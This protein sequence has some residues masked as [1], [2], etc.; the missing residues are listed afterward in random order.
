MT[1]SKPPIWFWIV[2]VLALLWNLLGVMAFVGQMAMTPDM[3]AQ[4]PEA[5]RIAIETR[6]VWATVAFGIAV[7]GGAVGS[8][9]LLLRSR[10]AKLL[11]IASLLGVIV[12]MA[13]ALS[14]SSLSDFGPGG[15]VMTVMIIGICALLVWLSVV[16]Q[17]KGWIR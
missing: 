14:A 16:A 1:N 12:Q 8:A 5:E 15:M 3:L 4:L 6:P 17:R 9:L 7:F 2:S 10:M 13:Q 11:L